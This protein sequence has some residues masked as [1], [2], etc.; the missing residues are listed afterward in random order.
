MGDGGVKNEAEAA[1]WFRKAAAQGMAEA[2]FKLG[3]CLQDGLGIP[4]DAKERSMFSRR[5]G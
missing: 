5:G 4:A 1:L 2:E 3:K